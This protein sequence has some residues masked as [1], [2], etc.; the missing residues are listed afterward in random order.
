MQ[1]AIGSEFFDRPAL[2]VAKDLLGKYLVRKVSGKEIALIINETEAYLGPID[3]ASH[4]RYGKTMRTWPMF[5]PGGTI[6]VYL[7]YGMHWLINISCGKKDVPSAV[8]LRGAG[9]IVGPARL[10]KAL[11]IDKSLNGLLLGKK[12]GL[13]IEDRGV[14]VKPKDIEKTPRIG[15]NYA[16]EYVE[17]PWRFVLKKTPKGVE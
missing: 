2:A 13:W 4:A 6:Y 3:K 12:A 14:T 5:E 1:K 16:E 8:L 15:I 7:T 10:T 17:K 11:A 9:D